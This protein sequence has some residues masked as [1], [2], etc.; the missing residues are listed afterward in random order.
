MEAYSWPKK[1][2]GSAR[3]VGEGKFA[4]YPRPNAP[5]IKADVRP[6]ENYYN[7]TDVLSLLRTMSTD[8]VQMHCGRVRCTYSLREVVKL[9]TPP[10]SPPNRIPSPSPYG[11][12]RDDVLTPPPKKSYETPRHDTDRL[13][14]SPT[15]RTDYYHRTPEVTQRQTGKSPT[16]SWGHGDL[17]NLSIRMPVSPPLEPALEGK[18]VCDLYGALLI[19]IKL[20]WNIHLS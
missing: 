4:I 2:G 14:V 18:K 15:P 16:T 10:K 17:E 19:W 5:R 3:K 20:I 12:P 8:S 7:Y 9:K 6:G 1:S 11:T 13:R